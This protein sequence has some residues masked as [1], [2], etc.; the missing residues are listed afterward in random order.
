MEF[1]N[2]MAGGRLEECYTAAA[3]MDTDG[4]ESLSFTELED[5]LRWAFKEECGKGGKGGKGGE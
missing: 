3:K 4:S 2:K 5:G 1:C